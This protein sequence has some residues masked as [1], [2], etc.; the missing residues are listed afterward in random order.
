[1]PVKPYHLNLLKFFVFFFT[2]ELYEVRQKSV[3]VLPHWEV[4]FS[5]SLP[6]LK[7]LLICFKHFHLFFLTIYRIKISGFR[8]PNGVF[9]FEIYIFRF[10]LN[11][12]VV[13]VE[14]K[15]LRKQILSFF[16]GN[17]RKYFFPLC[18]VWKRMFLTNF[19]ASCP[20]LN[21]LGTKLI[22]T[23]SAQI[24]QFSFV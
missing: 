8:S 5:L 13:R 1:M 24:V 10:K 3:L 2:V 9:V 19:P 17:V 12:I 21:Y 22:T 7:G 15:S 23:T 18:Q 20:L 14:F 16:L 6:A 4:Q 11:S